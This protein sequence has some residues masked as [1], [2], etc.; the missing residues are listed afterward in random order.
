MRCEIADGQTHQR[1]LTYGWFIIIPAGVILFPI[2]LFLKLPYSELYP[3][4][5]YINYFTTYYSDPDDDLAGITTS[6]YKLQRDTKKINKLVGLLGSIIVGYKG[7]YAYIIGAWFRG[8]RSW[9][10]HKWPF[11]T[12][13]RMVF[14]N[15]GLL[16]ILNAI[17]GY[18]DT[19]FSWSETTMWYEFYMDI[20]FL[21]Y[22]V[23]QFISW[24][25][26]DIIHITLDREDARGFLYDTES[27]KRRK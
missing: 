18:M 13:G 11:S 2:I 16:W 12:I 8:H 7:I 5:L 20:W 17:Y 4:F 22:L 15:F 23:T 26:G 27:K 19:F 10:S 1:Y 14:Y 21:P 24:S 6:E 3:L 25:L 9:A